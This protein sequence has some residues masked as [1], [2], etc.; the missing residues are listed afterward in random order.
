[1]ALVIE[2]PVWNIYKEFVYIKPVPLDDPFKA[3]IKD[4]DYEG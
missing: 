2:M 1:M 4:E 3:S